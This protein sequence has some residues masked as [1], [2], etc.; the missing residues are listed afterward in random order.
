VF[1]SNHFYS[2]LLQCNIVIGI[3][4]FSGA[5]LLTYHAYTCVCLARALR[6]LTR[7]LI[8]GALGTAEFLR[9]YKEVPYFSQCQ[10]TACVLSAFDSGCYSSGPRFMYR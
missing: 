1:R 9:L 8:G 6:A 5:V 4:L 2:T 7:R 10:G 3:F